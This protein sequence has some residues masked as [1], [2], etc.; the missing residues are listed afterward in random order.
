LAARRAP[1]YRRDASHERA[2]A[3]YELRSEGI[4]TAEAGVLAEGIAKEVMQT[5]E[6]T[7]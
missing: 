6:A 5:E 4:T 3:A 2:N 1:A 7:R